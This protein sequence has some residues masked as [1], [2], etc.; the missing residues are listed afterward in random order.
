MADALLRHFQST[1]PEELATQVAHS[2]EKL[3]NGQYE[4]ILRS[5]EAKLLFG[6][7]Q[8]ETLQT[9]RLSD[10]DTWNDFIFQRMGIFLA[11]RSRAELQAVVFCIGYAALLAFVQS[12]V[13]GPP[14]AFDVAES[15]LP[16]DVVSDK[17]ARHT[18]RQKLLAGFTVDG[19]AA[20]KLTPNIE[21]L[22]LADAIFTN[23][24]VLKNIK[25]ARWAKLR[26]A[27]FHQRLLSEVSSTIQEVIYDD[28][29]LL[30]DELTAAS[31]R[32]LHVEFLLER[33]SI[34][35]HHGLDKFA[36]EDLEKAKVEN[37]F[38]FAL[39]GML[40]KRT[41]YQQKDVSQL[42][43]L[44]KSAEDGEQ[45]EESSGSATAASKTKPENLDLNDDTLLESIS[46]T[47]DKPSDVSLTEMQN[48]ESL[49]PVLQSLD[50]GDQPK[51]QPLDSTILLLVASSITNTLPQNGLTREETLPYATRVLDGGSSNW[52]VYT[53]ALLVRSRIE[54]YKSRTIERGLLQLQALVDQVIAETTPEHSSS[55]EDSEKSV[56]TSTFLPKAKESESAPVTERVRYIFQLAT[57]TRWELEAEL[58]SRWVQLGGLR[59]ALEIYE[60]LEMWAEAALCWA[61]TEREDKAKRIVRRQLFH[62]TGGG[63]EKSEVDVGEDEE[64]L[65]PARDPAPLDA[66]RLYCI[67][68]DID[69][70][71]D[72]YEKAWE[73]SN[74][75]YARAQ[76]SIGRHFMAAKDMVRA[77]EAYSKSLRVNQLN[78]QSWFALGCALL[79][80]AQFKRAVEAFS[81]CVQ[82]DDTDAES[83]SNLAAALLRTDEDDSDAPVPST[84][85]EQSAALDDEDETQ[86]S[87]QKE[88]TAGE[89]RQQVRFDALKA[90]KRAASL[91][92]ESH[93]IWENVLI[94]AASLRPPSYQDILTA[95]RQIIQLRGPTDGEKC[96]DVQIL[97]SLVNHIISSNESGYDPN[98]PGLTRMTVKFIDEHIVPLITG[99]AELWHLVTKLA[100]WRDKPSTALDAEEKAWRA[101]T[102]QPGWESNGKEEQWNA[103]VEATVRLCDSYES[104]GP[105]ERTEGMAA[106][107]GEV[108]MKDWKFKARSA[109]RGI[110]GRGKDSWEGTEGW[111]RLKDVMEQLRG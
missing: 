88:L 68:G 11:D 32:T 45:V 29:G 46:F 71:I 2:I 23:P 4:D 103:V 10:F 44:A 110:M 13:T 7:E 101:V 64:W 33:A 99:S 36:R 43:V 51:L 108:V 3:E 42:V 24:A 79:E 72:M 48:L 84:S 95:Q 98:V 89:K 104:L 111:E 93:R 35:I 109:L 77:A 63:P 100:L 58:A 90:L 86:P 39:V 107:S 31:D 67:L 15:L 85:T 73:V 65:G 52:Q 27:F 80:L 57:P 9:V 5:S 14:L 106:G 92:H 53:Q 30:D 75:R 8:N 16:S 50:P 87:Q 25:A 41:K 66:P 60:R 28:L 76:R 26:S 74:Q 21:L 69:Q 55:K 18:L 6:H 34:H 59:S 38:Q 81:R 82:L 94:V 102:N 105:K 91:K 96:I 1:L 97:S 40:G 22:C 12:N 19:I 17:H 49:P 47:K 70:S 78:Q 62:A 54:G 61:A 56:A 83:W 37:Q 20:Y